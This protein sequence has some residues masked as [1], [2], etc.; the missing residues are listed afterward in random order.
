G[1]RD[2][3]LDPS[4]CWA[5]LGQGGCLFRPLPGH[6]EAHYTHSDTHDETPRMWGVPASLACALQ[7]AQKSAAIQSRH[8]RA[9]FVLRPLATTRRA[10]DATAQARVPDSAPLSRWRLV[11]HRIHPARVRAG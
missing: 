2:T 10:L 4:D 5:A 9:G 1:P 6:P 8:C 7:R 11:S 3:P